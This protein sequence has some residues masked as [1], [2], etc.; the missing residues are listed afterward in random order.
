MATE[1]ISKVDFLELKK[2]GLS[3]GRYPNIYVSYKVADTMDQKKEYVKAAGLTDK[4]CMQLIKGYL[5]KFGETKTSEKTEAVEDV[6]PSQ[7]SKNSENEEK[8]NS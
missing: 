8:R 3:E 2:Q 4:I 5:E 1:P 7:L 6:L